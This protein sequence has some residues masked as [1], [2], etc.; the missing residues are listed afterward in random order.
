MEKGNKSINTKTKSNIENIIIKTT[1]S[2]ELLGITIDKKKNAK[3]HLYC[4]TQFAIYKNIWAKY[5]KSNN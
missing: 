2:V 3:K 1:K 5:K 4:L